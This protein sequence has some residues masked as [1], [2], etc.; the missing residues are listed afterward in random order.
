MEGFWVGERKNHRVKHL[1]FKQRSRSCVSMSS[2]SKFVEFDNGNGEKEE[3]ATTPKLKRRKPSASSCGYRT[4]S[5]GSQPT[6]VLRSRNRVQEVVTPTSTHHHPCTV[7]SWLIDNN[8]VLP[9]EKVRHCSARG[10][11]PLAEGKVCREGIECN[12]CQQVFTLGGFDSHA[13]CSNYRPAANI[14]LE[15][16]KSLLDCQMQIM[17]ERGKK[18]C[19]L[20]PQDVMKGNFPRIENDSFCT[21]CQDGGDLILCDRCPSAFHKSCIGFEDVPDGDWF[22]PACCCVICGCSINPTIHYHTC[23]QCERKY[24]TSCLR[25]RSIDNLETNPKGNWFCSNNCKKIFL[26]LHERLGK[27]IS[28]GVDN[29][30]WSLWKS[31][32]SDSDNPNEP[33]NDAATETYTK[34]N[35][36]LQVMQECFKHFKKPHT[37]GYLAED[38]IFS[39]GSHLDG[40]NFQGF[41]TVL[42]EKN[43]A[44]ITVATVR[45]YGAKV[46]EVPLIGTRLQHRQSGMCR[47]LMHLIEKMLMDLGVER[48]VLPIVPRSVGKWNTSFGFSDIKGSD[49]LQFLDY[50]FMHFEDTIMCQKCLKRTFLAEP[51]P[52]KGISLD[53]AGSVDDIDFDGSSVHKVSFT[54]KI[55]NFSSCGKEYSETF[56]T[57]DLRWR[58]LM[59]P[60]GN[61]VDNLSV[62]LD[63]RG[64][65]ELPLGWSRCVKFSLTLVN[66]LQHSQSITR[67]TKHMFS[68]KVSN[69]GFTSLI[70]LDELHDHCKGFLV[71]DACIIIANVAVCM[72]QIMISKDLKIGSATL[73]P[74]E[75]LNQ[76]QGPPLHK[77]SVKISDPSSAVHT[78]TGSEHATPFQ[79]TAS[80]EQACTNIPDSRTYPSLKLDSVEVPDIFS[81]ACKATSFGHMTASQDAASFEQVCIK[82]SDTRTDPSLVEKFDVVTSTSAS[83][84]MNFR[85][86]AN[87][88]KD[89]VP[90]LEEVC[91]RHPSFIERQKESSP[92]F[93]EWAF[94]ALGKV[95]HFL[96]TK[97]VKDMTTSVCE[98]LDLLYKEL[99]AFKFD[100]TWL[101]PHVKTALGRSKYVERAAEVKRLRENVKAL[102]IVSKRLEAKLVAARNDLKKAEESF[103]ERIMDSELGYSH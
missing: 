54:W 103:D 52:S 19:R 14:F 71:N 22:C 80:S 9:R 90:L 46:A 44:L 66:Q 48:L 68:K 39:R 33:D 63:V 98:D 83:E 40:M 3:S 62:Y 23:G 89:F 60:K 10:S 28:V 42:L 56:L 96:K 21:V 95:L 85:G 76:E 87:I 38:I 16:G 37:G 69:C 8:V 31:M 15:D 57:G 17:T 100:L 41:Y 58:M 12:C 24:H 36:A 35:L 86:L 61:T 18:S 26:G 84:L 45:I 101:E 102:E 81:A 30:T 67:E 1:A 72:A 7:L 47:V 75:Y 88:K 25:K 11:H 6:R 65:S 20:A 82:L 55:Y 2:F 74:V 34:L 91:S 70:P 43:D 29:L 4:H 5:D 73:R 64:A 97:K 79:E 50:R 51:C 77:G 78:T 93:T 27:Q 53:V 99:T 59:Y 92:Q 49:R 13:G 32:K 94:T